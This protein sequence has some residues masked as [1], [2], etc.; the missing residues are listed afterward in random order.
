[1]PPR[2]ASRP[3]SLVSCSCNQRNYSHHAALAPRTASAV[4]CS[5]VPNAPAPHV[6]S[7]PCFLLQQA[8]LP[9]QQQNDI[10]MPRDCTRLYPNP[11]NPAFATYPYSTVTASR[12][13]STSL[14]AALAP[15]F[16]SP[17]PPNQLR[18]WCVTRPTTCRYGLPCASCAT[19]PPGWRAWRSWRASSTTTGP[20]AGTHVASTPCREWSTSRPSPSP[21]Q[22]RPLTKLLFVSEYLSFWGSCKCDVECICGLRCCCALVAQGRP[23]ETSTNQGWAG[24]M[25][26]PSCL[27]LCPRTSSNCYD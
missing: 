17:P 8:R 21:Q 22:V 2:T 5:E 20:P 16:L 3:T 4:P 24:G 23:P 7:T 13:G 6:L 14:T 11:P 27:A 10:H 19:R 9:S 18:C 1:M 12:Q 15:R 25:A 26:Y